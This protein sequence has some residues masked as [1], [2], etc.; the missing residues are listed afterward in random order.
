MPFTVHR[1]Q[2]DETNLTLHEIE[3]EQ[4]EARM[5]IDEPKTPFVHGTSL[6]PVGDDDS[7]YSIRSQL[8]LYWGIEADRVHP[9]HPCTV[10]DLDGAAPSVSSGSSRRGSS[11]ADQLAANTSANAGRAPGEG[12]GLA[13][14]LDAA[15]LA[16]GASS[17]TSG[18]EGQ[19]RPGSAR[20]TSRSPSFSLP[21]KS[22]SSR[23]SSSRSATAAS[24]D[25]QRSDVRQ[26]AHDMDVDEADDGEVEEEDPD[27][28]TQ[29]KHAAFAAKRNQHYG[30]EAE[31]MK[32]AAAL[33]ARDE[34]EEEEDDDDS[35][36]LPPVPSVPNGTAAR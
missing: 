19:V 33:A 11:A 2:W 22:P 16:N 5:K 12:L 32:I 34:D 31:A 35:G 26:R 24:A 25:D 20:S 4:Q 3:R 27:P 10:F 18:S 6:N 28:E 8:R 1:L 14:G 9:N 30:N 13:V 36:G 17:T 29:A 7:K 23:R 21:P 15:D